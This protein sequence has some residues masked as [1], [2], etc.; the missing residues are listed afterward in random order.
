M[1]GKEIN[2][3]LSKKNRQKEKEEK[4]E[5]SSSK[6]GSLSRTFLRLADL[7]SPTLLENREIVSNGNYE[8]SRMN[9]NRIKYNKTLFHV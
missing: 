1:D 6:K 9:L 8:K 3:V 2:D 7:I 4:K 5:C